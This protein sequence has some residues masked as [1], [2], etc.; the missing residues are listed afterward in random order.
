MN[1]KT[2]ALLISVERKSGRLVRGQKVTRY[3][4]NK[5]LANWPYWLALAIGIGIGSLVSWFYLASSS[6]PSMDLLFK[7][8]A[9]SFFVS[10]PTLVLIYSLIFTMMSQIQRSGIKATSQVPFWLPIT[11]QEHTL[12]SILAN[13]LGFP[14]AS[15]LAFASGIIVFSIFSGL[16]SAALTASLAMFAAVLM[17]SATTEILRILQV[18]FLGAVYKSTGKAAIWVRFIGSLAFF[19]VFY[20]LYFSIVGSGS[21]TFIQDIAAYQNAFWFVPFV[22]LGMSV[23][24][25]TTGLLLQGFIMASLS[26][27][28]ITGLFFLA[29]WLNGQFGL[30]EPPA[31][32]VTKGVYIPRRGLLAKLGFSGEEAALIR[33]D[34]KAFT[35]RRELMTI[36]IGPIVIILIPIL[37]SLNLTS[38]D[39]P[40][41]VSTLW[42]ALTFLFPASIM[43]MSLGNFMIGEEG[44]A[45]WRIY[46]SPISKHNLVKSKYFII[47]LFALIVVL[48]AGI[49]G[50][51]AFGSTIQ[52]AAVMILEAVMLVFA[53]GAISLSM[54]IKGADFN[55]VPRQRMIHLKWGLTSF[56]ACFLAGAAILSPL[57]PYLISSFIPGIGAFNPYLAVSISAV[58]AVVLTGVFYRVALSNAETL[59]AEAEI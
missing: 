47:V 30:Y 16:V 17:A 53:L 26:L 6:D 49:I 51:I 8:G 25:L 42:I 38:G 31:I 58:V 57:L 37:Q 9:L 45:M 29:T 39:A 24:F 36:F 1:L 10:L 56:I 40:S 34:L 35:R 59:L 50:L 48:I 2:V 5:F 55:E 3:K 41:Q 11:W 20:I 46:A 13:M 18:R 28:F 4:E 43:A 27:V 19:V 7:E 15:I 52:I 12:A 32:T 22:W 21:L 54:G 14:L 33:K 23:Y 44:K